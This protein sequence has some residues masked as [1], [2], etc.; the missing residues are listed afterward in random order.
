MK[1][2]YFITDDNNKKIAVQIDLKILERYEQE[3]EDLLD[4]IIVESRKQE[5][6]V[7]WAMVK[8]Q[9]RKKKKI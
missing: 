5:E 2:V 7:G 1:G 4:V 8:K 6:S 9:L 3:I